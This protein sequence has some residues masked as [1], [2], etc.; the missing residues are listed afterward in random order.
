[1]HFANQKPSNQAFCNDWK[2]HGTQ[3]FLHPLTKFRLKMNQLSREPQREKTQSFKDHFP[4]TIV[5]L[6]RPEKTQPSF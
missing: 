1:M 3:M 5:S 6:N 4:L 2:P